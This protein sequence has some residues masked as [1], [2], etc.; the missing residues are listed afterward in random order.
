VVKATKK[1]TRIGKLSAHELTL[2]DVVIK[3]AKSSG[4]SPHDIVYFPGDVVDAVT[5][6]VG[7][8]ADA[9]TH[10]AH[11]VADAATN[12]ADRVNEN[13]NRQD[14]R[15]MENWQNIMNHVDKAIGGNIDFSDKIAVEALSNA[16]RN[17]SASKS[18]TLKQLIQVRTMAKNSLKQK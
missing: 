14:Q 7:H 9:V 17:I 15:D 12:F 18:P 5:D 11:E 13:Q 16:I 4:L 6:A 1:M 2:L 8:A 10:A 3:K